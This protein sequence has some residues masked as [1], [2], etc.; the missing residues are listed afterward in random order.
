LPGNISD[1]STIKKLIYDIEFIQLKKLKLVLDRGFYCEKNLND[2]YKGEYKFLL[3]VKNNIKF[4]SN[5]IGISSSVI[6]EICYNISGFKLHGMEYK[7]I[8]PYKGKDKFGNITFSENKDIYVHVF[9]DRERENSEIS[10]FEAS[11]DEVRSKILLNHELTK[12]DMQ[13]SK[14][15][16]L[17]HNNPEKIVTYNMDA[18]TRHIK[19]FGFFALLSNEIKTSFEA[20]KIYRKRDMVEKAFENIKDRLEFDRTDVHSDRNL[21]GKCFVY[22]IALIFIS[23]IDKIMKS[24]N[25]YK[26]YT[27]HTLLDS[28]DIIERFEYGKNNFHYGEITKKQKDIY[29][30]F[31]V[32]PPNDDENL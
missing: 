13:L 31:G 11:I 17:I 10:K 29:S 4:V 27:M 28:L 1:V 23:Y 6:K 19:D 15:F 22:F 32:N 16:L 5:F 7:T 18:V 12:T 3:A 20:I 8:W 9:F 21:D 14:K 2:L 25:L 30:L 26:N 24:N